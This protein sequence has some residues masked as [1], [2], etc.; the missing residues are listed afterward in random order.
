MTAANPRD[1]TGNDHRTPK[2]HGLRRKADTGSRQ[3]IA[4]VNLTDSSG[5]VQDATKRKLVRA[6]VM[7]RYQRR[8]QSQEENESGRFQS[9]G[10]DNDL[11]HVFDYLPHLAP[12][13]ENVGHLSGRQIC[14]QWVPYTNE[15]VRSNQRVS[16]ERELET[17]YAEYHHLDGTCEPP[18]HSPQHHVEFLGR[19]LEVTNSSKISMLSFNALNSGSLDPFNTMPKLKNSRARALMYHCKPTHFNVPLL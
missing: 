17:T 9:Y 13:L 2:T 11:Y 10:H 19:N 18:L 14:G 4:F 7:R 16:L 12:P 1:H 5:P 6:H 8:K 15:S 3:Q